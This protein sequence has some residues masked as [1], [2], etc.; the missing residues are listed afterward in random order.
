MSY[1]KTDRDSQSPKVS[2]YPVSRP[3]VNG[4]HVL[5]CQARGMVP[6]LVKFR[7]EMI[8]Q[9]GKN[10]ELK[11]EEMLE[12]K[13]EDAEVK[14]TSMLIVD[15]QKVKINRFVCCVQHQQTDK[16]QKVNIPRFQKEG[17]ALLLFD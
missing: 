12:Q 15:K 7:W 8:D 11:E 17:N 5:L 16:E 10:V 13:D 1:K 3:Q 6:D 2:V 4:K 14:I 9:N